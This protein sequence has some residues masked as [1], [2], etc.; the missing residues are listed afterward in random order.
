[1]AEP[2][3]RYVKMSKPSSGRGLRGVQAR[4]RFQRS[5]GREKQI[6]NPETGKYERALS[7]AAGQRQLQKLYPTQE[8]GKSIKK[9][10]TSKVE[11]AKRQK[12]GAAEAK[13]KAE[14]LL[15]ETK[16]KRKEK[17]AKAKA[18]KEAKAKAEPAPPPPTTGRLTRGPGPEAPPP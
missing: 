6:L 12:A 9:V 3:Y 18:E 14:A 17:E 4:Q 5:G 15:A 2:K 13:K 7:G 16:K 11:Q 10:E 8:R 1:M